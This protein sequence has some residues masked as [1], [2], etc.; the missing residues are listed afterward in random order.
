LKLVFKQSGFILGLCLIIGL[1]CITNYTATRVLRSQYH[2]PRNVVV[3]EFP[4]ICRVFLGKWAEILAG[5]FGIITLL[6]ALLAYWT[7]MSTFLYNIGEFIHLQI[8]TNHTIVPITNATIC[9]N[10]DINPS[11]ALSGGNGTSTF[12]KL[13]NHT[14]VPLYLILIFL[15][16]VNLKDAVIFTKFNSLGTISVFYITILTITKASMWGVN[17]SSDPIN[18]HFVQLFN[19]KFS[20]LAGMLCLAFFLHNCVITLLRNNEKQENNTR[21]LRLGYFLVG[22]TYTFIGG[23]FFITYPENKGCIDQNFINNLETNDLMAVIARFFLFFQLSTVFPLL[24]FLFR[25]QSL[26]VLFKI[27]EYPGVMKCIALN[28]CAMALCALIAIV[29]PQVGDILGWSGAICGLIYIFLLPALVSIFI[30][31]K[32]KTI[33]LSYYIIQGSLIALGVFILGAKIISSLV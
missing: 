32:R 13:W 33:K 7:L 14:T 2:V 4:D 11:F 1:G 22:L 30:R 8:S 3:F 20:S 28:L 26:Y 18:E 5:V 24:M 12:D 9:T 21:D 15:P 6:G 17:W 25:T 31:R 27:S 16:V 10:P 23:L 19:V 29:Y